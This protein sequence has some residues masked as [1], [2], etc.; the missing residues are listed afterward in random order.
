MYV[1]AD[2]F[3]IPQLKRACFDQ[4][5]EIVTLRY[6]FVRRAFSELPPGSPMHKW[7]VDTYVT[8]F[9]PVLDDDD[10]IGERDGLPNEFLLQVLLQTSEAIDKDRGTFSRNLWK[11]ATTT[12]IQP[13]N[14]ELLADRSADRRTTMMK[15]RLSQ[16]R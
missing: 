5:F 10:E 12:S 2:R 14:I 11:F 1:F 6:L 13:R 9:D 8:K 3:L 4:L 16:L 7:L 15:S